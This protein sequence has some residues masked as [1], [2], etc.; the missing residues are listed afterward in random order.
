MLLQNA[1]RHITALTRVAV[2]N[3]GLLRIKLRQPGPQNIHRDIHRPRQRAPGKFHR[4]SD[5]HNLLAIKL[6]A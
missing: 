4:R 2:G 3:G 6:A 1:L 5:I